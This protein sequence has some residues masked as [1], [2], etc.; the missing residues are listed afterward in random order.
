MNY[1]RA[2]LIVAALFSA[3]VITGWR[4]VS[5]VTRDEEVKQQLKWIDRD[6]YKLEQRIDDLD[7]RVKAL[8]RRP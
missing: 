8:E 5:D 1:A 6:A 3:F 4:T 7:Q 2:Y